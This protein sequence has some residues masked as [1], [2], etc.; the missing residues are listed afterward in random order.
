M[1]DERNPIDSLR[2]MEL[3]SELKFT[4]PPEIA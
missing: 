3:P 4:S 2:I 1:I